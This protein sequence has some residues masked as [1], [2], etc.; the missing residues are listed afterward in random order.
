[1]DS[2]QSIFSSNKNFNQMHYIDRSLCTSKKHKKSFL[3]FS[4]YVKQD[5][6]MGP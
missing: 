3:H 4:R 2:V 1:M 6:K 5:L